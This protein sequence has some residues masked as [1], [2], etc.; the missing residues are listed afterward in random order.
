M[1]KTIPRD[2]RGWRKSSYSA[3]ETNCV[4]VAYGP[5]VGIRDTKDRRGGHLAVPA[6]AWQAFTAGVKRNH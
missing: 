4:E 5:S 2:S 3:Q 6:T 1:T